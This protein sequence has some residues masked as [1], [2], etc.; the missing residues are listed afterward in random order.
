MLKISEHL[1]CIIIMPKSHQK[2]EKNCPIDK[3]MEHFFFVLNQFVN[4]SHKIERFLE[5]SYT[6]EKIA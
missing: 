1:F 4:L 5:F 6:F 2:V 3:Q